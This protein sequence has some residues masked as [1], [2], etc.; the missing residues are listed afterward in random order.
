[1]NKYRNK[2]VV[3]SGV[4]YD[5]ILES[6]YHKHLQ[7][8]EK[9]GEI[10]DLS[11]HEHKFKFTKA[12][13]GYIPD[14]CYIEKGERIWVDTKG[15]ETADFRIKIRLWKYY[16]PGPL[17]IVKRCGGEFKTTKEIIPKVREL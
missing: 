11:Y 2:K 1:M 13:I 12:Q 9:A 7:L 4:T 5:S 8:L 14:F 6:D 3:I 17:R 15:V 10:S 16:G